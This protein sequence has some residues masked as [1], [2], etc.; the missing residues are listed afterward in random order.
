LRVGL[1]DIEGDL[2]FF[3]RGEDRIGK[4]RKPQTAFNKSAG[5]AEPFGDRVEVAA[6]VDEVLVGADFIGRRHVEPDDV[7][8][9][10]EFGLLG[11]IDVEDA[12]GDGMILGKLACV[13]EE[14]ERAQAAAT[15]GYVEHSPLLGGHHDQVLEEAL[16]LDIGGQ[17]L[18]EEVAVILADVGFGQP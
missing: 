15:R 16:G 9:Q 14:I 2:A 17:F 10:R 6:L 18:D 8:D 3:E 12:A 7:L 11:G 13:E 1:G 4:V 5:T